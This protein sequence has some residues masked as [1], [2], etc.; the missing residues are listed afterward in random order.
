MSAWARIVVVS[1]ALD[2]E[3]PGG[4]GFCPVLSGRPLA[5]SEERCVSKQLGAAERMGKLC[6][7]DQQRLR[8]ARVQ[9]HVGLLSTPWARDESDVLD[10]AQHFARLARASVEMS[11]RELAL[12][13]PSVD[14]IVEDRQHGLSHED[15]EQLYVR[16][17]N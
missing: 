9:Q 14:E 3:S 13:H 11:L 5:P 1:A 6:G 17:W 12:R 8:L 15:A 16:R 7:G 4:I 10:G 2:S